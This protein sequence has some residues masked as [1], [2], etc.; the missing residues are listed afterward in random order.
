MKTPLLSWDIVTQQH[1]GAIEVDSTFGE[2]TE[3]TICLPPIFA[4]R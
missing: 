2:F 4:N 3:F 1:G